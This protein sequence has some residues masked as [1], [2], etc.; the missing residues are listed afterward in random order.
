M[1]RR[2]PRSTLFPYTTLFRSRQCFIE[3]GRLRFARLERTVDM[4]PQAL[5]IFVRSE[6]LRLAQYLGTLRVLPREGPPVQVFVVAPRAQRS[7]FEQA[8][9]SDARVVFHTVDEGG[10]LRSVGVRRAPERVL[11]EALYLHLAA[12]KPPREQFA[13][14]AER[15]RYQ[16]WQLQRGIVAAGALGFAACALYAGVQWVDA[17]Q[18]HGRAASQQRDARL[19]AAQYERITAGFPVTQTSTENLKVAV[20]EVRR[21]AER[22]ARRI[23]GLRAGPHAAALRYHVG[24]HADRRHR[25]RQRGVRRGAALHG[26]AGAEAA[27]TLTREELRKLLLPGLAALALVAAGAGLVWGA[28]QSVRS[29][30]LRLAAAEADRRESTERLTRIAEEEREVKEKLDVYQQL[31]Q[32][33]ILGEEHRLEWAD[34]IT[35]IRT[36]RELLDLRYRVDRQKL[37]ISAPGKP[38]NVDFY[39]STMKVELALLHEEDLLRFLAD[40]RASGNAYYSVKQC[41]ITRT[42][43]AATGASIVPRLR[44]DCEIDLITI[45][46]RAAKR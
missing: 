22:G 29:A 35:R 19:A 1:I 15:R 44:A 24:G 8:L 3:A 10:A 18:V 28:Q 12:K 16:V 26:H 32:L 46:D 23:A 4:V 40:L 30:Q 17:L 20:V 39:A 11:G 37:L 36:Q 13:S 41:L 5:A 33:N 45:I 25:R 31:K 14:S 6:M 27:V 7:T 38:A 2:P 42:G 21:I 43:Q 34:A 9:V